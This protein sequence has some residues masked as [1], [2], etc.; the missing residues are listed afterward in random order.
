MLLDGIVRAGFVSHRR[1]AGSGGALLAGV[2]TSWPDVYRLK[3][4]AHMA[5]AKPHMCAEIGY[6]LKVATG[7]PGLQL[8]DQAWWCRVG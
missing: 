1:P 5:A 7:R 4:D 2:H 3:E 8:D 6:A